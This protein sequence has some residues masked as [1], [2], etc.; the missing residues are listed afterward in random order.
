MLE[1]TLTQFVVALFMSLGALCFFVWAVLSGFFVDVENIK[2]EVYRREVESD[3]RTES[4][5]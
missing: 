3:E 1:L 4:K 2:H 5:E